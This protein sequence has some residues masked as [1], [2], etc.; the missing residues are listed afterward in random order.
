MIAPETAA[1]ITAHSGTVPREAATPPRM[2]AISPGKTKPTNA[3]ASSAG[4]ANTSQ[5]ENEPARE[6]QD[7]VGDTC[8]QTQS[9]HRGSPRPEQSP[10]PPDRGGRRQDLFHRCA[11]ATRN[12]CPGVAA[13]TRYSVAATGRA[14]VVMTYLSRRPP[15]R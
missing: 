2:T 8:D 4:K 13:T 9:C 1:A 6:R 5:R 15:A 7:A 11:A 12:L 10:P 3:E 14:F